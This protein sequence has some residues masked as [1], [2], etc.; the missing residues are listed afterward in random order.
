MVEYK[1]K[2]I[3]LQSGGTRNFYYK[4]SSDGKKTQVSKKEYLEKRIFR[5]KGGSENSKNFMSR[6][7]L[8]DSLKKTL[9]KISKQNNQ[10]NFK[11]YKIEIENEVRK[12]EQELKKELN[13]IEPFTNEANKFNLKY[14]EYKGNTYFNTTKNRLDKERSLRGIQPFSDEDTLLRYKYFDDKFKGKKIYDETIKRL[15]DEKLQKNYDKVFLDFDDICIKY[16]IGKKSKEL[17]EAF[18]ENALKI[19]NRNL[20]IPKVFNWKYT[21]DNVRAMH[22]KNNGTKVN[23]PYP[24]PAA[25]SWE[26]SFLDTLA[27]HL[28]H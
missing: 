12:L 26:Y 14:E 22:F 11:N 17:G 1:K 13:A 25:S 8:I 28:F 23:T 20:E 7:E 9:E 3:M 10:N 24:R 4:I 6:K 5:K 19:A 27:S 18:K 2:K 16:E 15:Y 21:F